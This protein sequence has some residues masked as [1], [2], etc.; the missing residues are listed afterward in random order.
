M[1]TDTLKLEELTSQ[2]KQ[3][4]PLDK[5]RLIERIMPLLEQE[6]M[7]PQSTHDTL[8]AWADVY[9]G[10]SD[11]EIMEVER[12]ALDRSHFMKQEA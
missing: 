9:A 7:T 3:L 8:S 5:V 11:K 12:L 6:L 1:N 10:L 4:S 2:V